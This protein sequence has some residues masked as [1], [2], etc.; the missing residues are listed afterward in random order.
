VAELKAMAEVALLWPE[1]I[2]AAQYR[3]VLEV[4]TQMQAVID[5]MLLL[6]RWERSPERPAMEPVDLGEMVRRCWQPHAG[7]AAGKRLHVRILIP[8][9]T[10]WPANPELLR[11]V[12]GNLIS[13]AVEYSP[14]GGEIGI[15]HVEDSG[16]RDLVFDNPAEHLAPGDVPHLFERFWRADAARHG[17]GH[18]GLGLPLAKTCAGIM[19]LSLAAELDERTKQLRFRLHLPRRLAR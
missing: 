5:N 10:S 14:E 11:M 9:G 12:V 19:G 15:E 1:R 7:A 6:A 2:S 17:T 8:S 13:N 3:E 18:A 16:G 4:A